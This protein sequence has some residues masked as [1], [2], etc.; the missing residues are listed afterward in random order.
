VQG[1]VRGRQVLDVGGARVA[2]ADQDEDAGTG[3]G[4][5]TDQ[6]LQRVAAEQ[7]VG[8]EGV[9]TESGDR[10][11]GGRRL[12]D[13]RLGVGGRS[14]GDVAALAVGDDQQARLLGGRADLGQGR[15]AGRAEALEAGQLR[16]DRDAGRAGALDQATTVLDDGGRRLLGGG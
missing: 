6:R 13:Q 3:L 15:P 4:G 7:R 5:S 16:L 11:P 10:A 2:G 9:G 14:Y 12:T 1:S 8:G